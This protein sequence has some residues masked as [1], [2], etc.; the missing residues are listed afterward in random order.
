MQW[1]YLVR[2]QQQ[3][4]ELSQV[5]QRKWLHRLFKSLWLQVS[6]YMHT[7]LSQKYKKHPTTSLS[8]SSTY[9]RST[10]RYL[11]LLV[12]VAFNKNR[13]K[14]HPKQT[15]TKPTTTNK[16]IAWALLTYLC[17]LNSLITVEIPHFGSFITGSSKYF[18][19]I[20][21]T[22]SKEIK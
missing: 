2:S 15:N 17:N 1:S 12:N 3:R 8:S 10:T 20:L 16:L 18:T 21:K 6:L 19:P 14:T 11:N 13:K 5:K 4:K 7:S 9:F 22:K